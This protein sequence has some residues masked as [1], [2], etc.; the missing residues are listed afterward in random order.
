MT[1]PR[2]QAVL[3]LVALIVNL[4]GAIASLTLMFMVGRRNE[5]RIL[6][7]LFTLWVLAPYVALFMA[8][9][10][11]KRWAAST[12]VAL[13]IVMLIVTAGSVVI[14]AVVAIGPPRPQPAFWFL[15]VP[16]ASLLL[17]AI[18][19][20]LTACIAGGLLRRRSGGV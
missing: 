7:L 18:A 9:L 20:A 5:S 13:H 15:I 12:Q 19:V 11:S 4:T 10:V 2:H 1:N 17:A 8:N 14:Y 3:Q 6:M 16:P